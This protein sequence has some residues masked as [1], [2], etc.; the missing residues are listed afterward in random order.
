M[1]RV[2][3]QPCHLFGQV[4]RDD[5]WRA[6]CGQSGCS[7]HAGRAVGSGVAGCN[8][9]AGHRGASSEF[10]VAHQ[11]TLQG[12]PVLL[13]HGRLELVQQAFLGGRLP[14][15][16]PNDLAQRP[17]GK[18]RRRGVAGYFVVQGPEVVGGGHQPAQGQLLEGFTRYIRRESFGHVQPPGQRMLEAASV[19]EATGLE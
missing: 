12:R 11:H 4:F 2:L 3:D 14:G 7:C 9:Q 15:N 10:G 17:L 16:H 1:Q 5:E 6:W 19:T 13:P 18:R 8:I